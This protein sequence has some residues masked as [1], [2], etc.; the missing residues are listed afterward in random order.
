M[1]GVCL[2]LAAAC[3]YDYREK[4]IPNRLILVSAAAGAARQFFSDGMSGVPDW[5][6]KT[7]LAMALL[8]PFFK[9]GVVGAG[10]VKLYG[11]TAGFLPPEKILYFLFFSMLVAAILS[12]LKMW[13]EKSFGKLW[14]YLAAYL[15]AVSRTG[16][17]Q[18]YTQREEDRG[19]EGV[20]L[21]GPVLVSVLLYMGG[22]Y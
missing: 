11:I 16:R 18:L 14:R 15:E 20:C 12:L 10:D 17:P 21:S 2:L 5:L 8:Y 22:V 6:G 3:G 1:G 7:V 9:I 19:A 4:R 13:K